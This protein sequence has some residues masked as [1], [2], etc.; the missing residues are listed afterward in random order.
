MKIESIVYA[1]RFMQEN[2]EESEKL[3]KM[4]HSLRDKIK[5]LENCLLS[6][7]NFCG[8]E[9]NLDKV[10]GLASLFFKN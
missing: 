3:R 5:H 10:L 2:R 1:D 6:Y 9:Y 7:K 4:V 8:S